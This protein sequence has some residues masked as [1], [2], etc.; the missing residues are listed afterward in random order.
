[1]SN[2]KPL[3]SIK[4]LSISTQT[5]ELINNFN[6]EINA[7]ECKGISAPTGTGKTTLFNR[8][9][10]YIQHVGN[11]PGVTVNRKDGAIIG[12]PDTLVTDLPGIYDSERQNLSQMNAI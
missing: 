6:L 12:H 1:M 9:T 2:P 5:I 10:G 7:G 11:F 8:L 3:L 4:N